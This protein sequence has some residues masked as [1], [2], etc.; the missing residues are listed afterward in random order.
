MPRPKWAESLPPTSGIKDP[1]VRQYLDALTNTWQLRNGAIGHD[2]RERFVTK[3]EFEALAGEAYRGYISGAIGGVTGGPPGGDPGSHDAI[4]TTIVNSALFGMLGAR[5]PDI[6]PPYELLSEID[7]I[8]SAALRGVQITKNG[9]TRLTKA[10]DK[11]VIDITALNTTIGQYDSLIFGQSMTSEGRAETI[12]LLRATYGSKGMAEYTNAQIAE[13]NTVTVTSTSAIAR[14]V[15]A[16]TSTV[17]VTRRVFFNRATEATANTAAPVPE[18]DTQYLTL[19]QAFGTRTTDPI[20]KPLVGDTWFVSNSTPPYKRFIWSGSSWTADNKGAGLSNYSDAGITT[21]RE[22]RANQDAALAKIVDNIWATVA[23]GPNTALAQ[24]QSGAVVTASSVNG[25]LGAFAQQWTQLQATVYD[26]D[27]VARV[28]KLRQD[29]FVG[30]PANG[31][32]FAWPG[33]NNLDNLRGAFTV[34]LESD[35]VVG[36]FGMVMENDG[37]VGAQTRFDFGVRANRFWIA[38]PGADNAASNADRVPFIVENGKVFLKDACVSN[39]IQSDNF[40]SG[41]TG[42]QIRRSDGSAEFN[43]VWIR[44]TARISRLA[45]EGGIEGTVNIP[46]NSPTG[47]HVYHGENRKVMVTLWV[48][49]GDGTPLPYISDMDYNSFRI[50]VHF[51]GASG[52]IVGY[53]YW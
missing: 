20:F 8:L 29:M 49:S 34:R 21:E 16:M 52:T 24:I 32:N 37:T 6:R 38:D 40:S 5:I 26:G 18:A 42:W 45:V 22:T 30:T 19:E 51:D 11:F 25:S 41:S 27:G 46:N 47:A 4:A 23:K 2:D 3:G 17:G 53:R 12:Q 15:A 36:G 9:I 10:T 39:I 50:R 1:E 44:G 7:G 31:S 35:G 13:I 48:V 28:D 14:I 43:N 33:I